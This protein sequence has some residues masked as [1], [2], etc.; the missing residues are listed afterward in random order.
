[1]LNYTDREHNCIGGVYILV[2][3]GAQQTN[4]QDNFIVGKYSEDNKQDDVNNGWY[5]NLNRMSEGTVT[6]K[7]AT[8]S[9]EGRGFQAERIRTKTLRK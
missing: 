6:A 4:N 8:W 5:A 9:S 2:G 7:P 1:M 3:E